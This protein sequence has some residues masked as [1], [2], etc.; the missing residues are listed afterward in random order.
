MRYTRKYDINKW[1]APRV[2]G[3]EGS[4][5]CKGN[6]KGMQPLPSICNK[7]PIVCNVIEAA[8]A[9]LYAANGT[10]GHAVCAAFKFSMKTSTNLVQSDTY[11]ESISPKTIRVMQALCIIRDLSSMKRLMKATSGEVEA[12]RARNISDAQS[13]K[14]LLDLLTEMHA[15]VQ[16][17]DFEIMAV[18]FI[19]ENKCWQCNLVCMLNLKLN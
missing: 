18:R 16:H 15:N 7:C 10:S 4:C 12:V 9:T 19:S 14:R 5:R 13:H 2:E 1:Q 6:W 11:S 17:D 8:Y 3:I